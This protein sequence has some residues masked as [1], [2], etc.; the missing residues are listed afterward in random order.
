MDSEEDLANSDPSHIR[1]IHIPARRLCTLCRQVH[2]VLDVQNPNTPTRCHSCQRR[3]N[4]SSCS[5]L[6]KKKHFYNAK[7]PNQLFKTCQTCRDKTINCNQKQ[8]EAAAAVGLR[9]CISGVHQVTVEDCT[10]PG[11]II[12]A[13]CLVCLERWHETYAAQVAAA[14]IDQNAEQDTVDGREGVATEPVV[15]DGEFG[16]GAEWMDLDLPDDSAVSAREK[17]LLQKMRETLA[18][19]K[20]QQCSTCCERTFDIK[21]DN[22]A[23]E[24]QR[25]HTDKHQDGKLWSNANNVNP[26]MR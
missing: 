23:Y 18:N 3:E 5:K 13:S 4:C 2:A 14:A 7:Q 6:K 17:I 20:M 11:G 15:N 8:R 9:W 1:L 26:G 10:S 16:D 19:V 12:H 25:C 22:P 21:S 24:C